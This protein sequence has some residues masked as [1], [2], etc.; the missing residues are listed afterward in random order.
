MTYDQS[1]H[2]LLV[3]D[4]P[5]DARYIREL[6]QEAAGFSERPFAERSRVLADRTE[7]S[8]SD[9]STLV[10]ETR[11]ED[12]LERLDTDAIDIVLLDLNLP[13]SDG[14]DTL[15]VV[16]DHDPLVPIVVLTG[17][18]DRQTG[19]DALRRGADEYL[20]KDELT[21][22]LLVRS[23]Y[24]AIERKTHERELKQYE[25]LVE[26]STDATAIVDADGAIRFL[27]PAAEGILGY[28]RE[29]LRGEFVFDYIHEGDRE[30]VVDEFE[31]MLSDPDYRGSEEFRF[32]HADGPWIVLAARARN[33]LDDPSINGVVIY[34][35]DVTE[36]TE[37]EQRL[38]ALNR[39]NEV[40]RDISDAVIEQSTRGEIE[41]IA[42]ERLAES[43][44]YE[45]AWVGETHPATREIEQRVMAG[46]EGYLDDV[47]ISIDPDDPESEGPTG[48]ALRTGETQTMQH[49][50][51]DPR[52]EPWRGIAEEYGFDASAAIPIRHEDTIFGVL[53]VY[54]GRSDGFGSEERTVIDHL[55]EVLGH[56]IASVQRKQALMSDTAVEL[57]LGIPDVGDDVDI[58]VDRLELDRAVPIGNDEFLVYGTTENDLDAVEALAETLPYW[59]E[60]TAVDDERDP[61]RFQA[62]LSEPPMLSMLAS[63]GGSVEHAVIEDGDYR[64]TVHLPES[65]D[66]RT[67]IDTLQDIYPQA[68][69]L[70]RRQVSV[71]E[72]SAQ[73]MTEAWMEELTDRQLTAI[74]V[75]YFSG[76]FE[77][78]RGSSG[79][80]VAESLGVSSPTFHQHVRSAERKLLD[81]VLSE[82]DTGT[83]RA[84]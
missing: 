33:L 40:V 55:G 54:T 5:G 28:D 69:A 47:T 24:H 81:A 64:I 16:R 11:L 1:P 20:V 62:R 25:A 78:P 39:L 14:L 70:A 29:E 74:E 22:D 38:Q 75:A 44:S 32:K 73:R 2:I 72:A 12:G 71:S 43:N 17:V 30:Q 61:L 37:Y 57:E 31:A 67:V 15:S 10:H 26:E 68:D 79:E 8:D 36:R 83:R 13:D 84:E 46:A 77:W 7:R 52:Y 58:D 51:E 41:Q 66:V 82:A 53:N 27:T 9:Q 60:V 49:V 63:V 34:A 45:F 35:H 65:A 80:E 76:F 23:L 4:N 42:C 21:P 50:R 19:I 59:G 48:R 18:R 3:E 56:A 6:L